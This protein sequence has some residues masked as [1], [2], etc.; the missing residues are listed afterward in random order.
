VEIW[1]LQDMQRLSLERSEIQHLE[2]SAGWLD[3][4]NWT[5]DGG[6]LCVE[7]I[8]RAHEHE[9]PVR[10]TYPAL[11]PSVPLVVRPKDPDERWSGHQYRDG[12]LCLEW[13]PDTWHPDVTGAQVLASAYKLLDIENPL[14]SDHKVVAPS[15][16]QLSLGQALRSSYGRFYVSGELADYLVTLPA[17]SSGLVEFS[18]QCQSKSFVAFVQQIRPT[19]CGAWEDASIPEGVRV[20]EKS[21]RMQ[22]GVFYR[23]TL[24]ANSISTLSKVS[25]IEK[26]LDLAGHGS[27]SFARQEGTYLMGLQDPPSGLL[28]LDAASEPHLLLLLDLENDTILHL[29]TIKPGISEA[30]IRI[31]TDLRGLSGKSVGIVGLGSLGSKIILSLART[32]VSRFFLVDD[33]IFLPEN[34]CRHVLDW[35]DVGEHKVDAVAALISRL[36]PGIEVDV[37]RLNLTG[38]ESTAGLS[39]V[40]NKLGRCD[41]VIDATASPRVFNTMAAIASTFERP[42]VWAEVYAGGI[43][44]MIAR[45]RPGRD[46]DPYTMRGAYHHFTSE[47]PSHSMLITEDY[48]GET[49]EGMVV[50]AS[51]ADVSVL[52]YHTTRLVIDT[53]LERE[54]SMFPYSMY[55]IGLARSWVFEAPFHTIPIDAANLVDQRELDPVSRDVLSETVDF[56]TALLEEESTEGTSAAGD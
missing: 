34:V 44:G 37:S 48:T 23:T 13:G 7:A 35:Q 2:A 10:M 42:L 19:G 5:L 47:M 28:L 54:P 31:P 51:D 50:T 33:D 6:S 3:G 43:G 39:A 9:Y 29:T 55:L 22:K 45:S 41:L 26:A 53:L 30:G 25:E 52:A 14:G 11:F 8:I 18:I 15:R 12:T 24:K 4:V 36:A 20:S 21:G 49:S 16:H 46:P 1:F 27:V 56:I 40:L 38:Q 32:G 17:G